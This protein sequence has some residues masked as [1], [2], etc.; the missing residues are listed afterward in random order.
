[1]TIERTTLRASGRRRAALP[2]PWRARAPRGNAPLDG[3]RSTHYDARLQR[4]AIDFAGTLSYF[5]W[6]GLNQIIEK[7]AALST[8]MR[9][10]HGHTPIEGIGSVVH[11]MTE[12]GSE[13]PTYDH[14]GSV[15]DVETPFANDLHVEYNAFGPAAG[16]PGKEST[17]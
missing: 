17:A 4:R 9:H 13:V 5:V 1:M 16:G 14:R 10:T 3:Q 6:D 15:F 8:A 7:D 11:T 2:C 12:R